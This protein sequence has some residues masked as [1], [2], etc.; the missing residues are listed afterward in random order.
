[1][2]L[3]M[4][5]K[6]NTVMDRINS[7][8][9]KPEINPFSYEPLNTRIL[10]GEEEGVFAW[11][12]VNYLNDYFDRHAGVVHPPVMFFITSCRTLA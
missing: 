6:A 2:R 4:E 7:I 1:M 9:L 8:L 12:T 3:L 11:I 5:D 10:S